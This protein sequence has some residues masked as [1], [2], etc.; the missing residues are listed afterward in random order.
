MIQAGFFECDITPP[1]GA[2]RPATFY[3]LRIEKYSD[4]L[5]I[6]A[7][8]LSDGKTRVALVGSDN[9]G[10][11]PVFLRR[12]KEALPGIDVIHSASH[13]HY[14][15]N[16][17]DKF[18]GID[19]A[20]EVL[21]RLV[22]VESV[23]HDANYYE[24]C[25]RQAITAVTMAF[26]N[27]QDVDF[28]FG[29]ARVEGLIFNRRI[30]MKDGSVK[31]HPGKGNPDSVGYAGPVDDQLGVMGVWKHGTEEL[32]GFAL[33]YS[34]H[35]CINMEGAT[36]DF[37]GVA[38]DTV[39]GTYGAKAG[40]VFLQ[41]ASGD[42]TQIDNMSLRKDTGKPIATKLGRALGGE[43]IRLLATA[44]RGPLETLKV[45]KETYICKR[46]K[47]DPDEIAAA[48]KKVQV[49]ED[50]NDYKIAKT[51]YVGAVAA[52]ADPNPAV[53]LA[54]LQ[55]G[56]LVIG[57]VPD[58][59]FARYALDFKAQ[60]KF[61][62]TWFSQLSVGRSY[63]PSPDAFDPKT[64]GGYEASTAKFVP[65]TGTE[66]TEIISRLSQLLTPEAVP[67]PVT[68]KPQNAVW[69]FNF[70]RKGSAN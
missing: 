20:D 67:P 27:L 37:P 28:S 8:A 24:F 64:G 50:S 51:L 48:E 1:L 34:C 29:S 12:L 30:R 19:E 10:C 39:R 9:V 44:D 70:K 66:I 31:T 53:E 23:A 25:L 68:V 35:A 55:I 40:A 60:S 54:V 32:L 2:E 6:R 65:E 22:L 47:V 42:I 52:K 49:Y 13:T 5:K 36:A 4:P 57:S 16:L 43:A 56:P 26:E 69:G 45:L 14:G 21:R 33:N 41:G 58:E 61:P 11:G 7:L 46:Q 59:P 15:G 38:I 63:I 3:K 62:F 18:P 17:R